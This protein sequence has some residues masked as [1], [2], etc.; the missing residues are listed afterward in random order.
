MRFYNRQH[1]FYC[2]IDLHAR[3]MYVCILDQQGNTPFTLDQ[4][5]AGT[6]GLPCLRWQSAQI[7][8]YLG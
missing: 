6:N 2:S 7:E 3:K 8:I 4:S 5:R 1:E